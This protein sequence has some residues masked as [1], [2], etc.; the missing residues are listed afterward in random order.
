MATHHQDLIPDFATLSVFYLTSVLTRQEKAAEPDAECP[1]MAL[2]GRTT[3][4]KQDAAKYIATSR[5]QSV[6]L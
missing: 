1:R 2:Y 3:F 4:H 5:S 6:V